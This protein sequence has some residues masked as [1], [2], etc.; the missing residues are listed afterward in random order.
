MSGGP[1]GSWDVQHAVPLQG[2]F[3]LTQSTEERVEPIG[4]GQAACLLVE[5]AEQALFNMP[6]SASKNT[7]QTLRLQRFDNISSL[8]RIVPCYVLHLSVTGAF[9]QHIEQVMAC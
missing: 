8:V 4:A 9:W 1:G 3:F 7:I 2:I 6:Y 5:S